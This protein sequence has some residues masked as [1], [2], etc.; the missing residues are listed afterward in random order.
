MKIQNILIVSIIIMSLFSISL[1]S[2]VSA[3]ANITGIIDSF[4]F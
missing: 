2:L 3:E 1:V 4:E